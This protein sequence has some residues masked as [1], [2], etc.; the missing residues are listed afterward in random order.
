MYQWP[1]STYMDSYSLASNHTMGMSIPRPSAPPP[2]LAMQDNLLENFPNVCNILP[3]HPPPRNHGTI[4]FEPYHKGRPHKHLGAFLCRWN[5]KG[6]LCGDELRATP[7]DIL[8]HLRQ[9]HGIVIGNKET[10]RCL[11][12]TAHGQCEEQLRFRSFGRHIIKHTGIRIKCSLCGTTMPARNDLATKHRHHHPNCSQADFI[13]IP[14]RNTE[15][16]C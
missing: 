2:I 1:G 7:K 16:P 6:A 10:Y 12:I 9:D 4:R 11:W 15:A 5:N 14:G 8:A 13:I 3:P